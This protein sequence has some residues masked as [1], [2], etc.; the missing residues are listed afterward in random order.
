ML[1]A[2]PGTGKT[3]TVPPAL[4]HEEWLADQRILMVEPRRMAARAAAARMADLA[5]Q[6][7]GKTFGYSVRHDR[8]MSRSTRVETVTEGIF[9]NRIQRDPELSGVGLVILDEFHE[10]SLESDMALAFLLEARDSLREDLRILVMSATIDAPKVA[11]FIAGEGRSA[12]VIEVEAP[13]YPIETIH[14]PPNGH[15]SI[16]DQVASTVTEALAKG[17]GDVLVFLPGRAEIG[18]SHRRLDRLRKSA[19]LVAEIEELHGS[20]PPS[21]QDRILRGDPGGRRRVILA[22]SIAETSVTIPGVRIVVDTGRRRTL[23]TDPRTGLPYLSTTA[24]SMAGAD[25]RR[26]RA[27]RTAPGICYRLWSRADEEHRDDHDEP[28]I[29]SADLSQLTLQAKLWGARDPGEMKWLDPPPLHAVGRAER[30]LRELGALDTRSRVTEHGKS[31]ASYGFHPRLGAIASAAGE[32]HRALA[33]EICAV[34]DVSGP[35]DIELAER[36]RSLRGGSH[37][38]SGGQSREMARSLK[39]WQRA[40]GVNPKQAESGSPAGAVTSETQFNELVGRLASAGFADRIAIRRDGRKD[41]HGKAR[42]VYQ[43]RHGGEVESRSPGSPLARHR[44]I[45][46]LDLDSASGSGRTG[47]LHLG[48]ELSAADA[49]KMTVEHIEEVAQVQLDSDGHLVAERVRKVD[50]MTVDRQPWRNPPSAAVA[51]AVTDE[52]QAR[53]CEWLPR[54]HSADRIRSRLAF[55]IS[56]GFENIPDPSS[57]H[58]QATADHWLLPQLQ[59]MKL[60]NSLNTIDVASA[61][62]AMVDWQTRQLLESEAPTSWV[63]PSGTELE[64]RYGV[65]DGDPGSVMMQARLQLLLGVDVQPTVGSTRTPITVEL[66]SPANR[67]V[68][69]TQDLPGFW[70]GSYCEVRAEMRSRYRKHSWPERP[71]ES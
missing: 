1:V 48:A 28:E 20:V 70:R 45:L 23:R 10:R 38:R 57:E 27:G 3:T 58:L 64:L 35:G 31:I 24:V 32:S 44:W 26:G 67:P 46:A 61:V 19:G 9:T 8:S 33:A 41:K 37:S 21:E 34:L 52:V 42:A 53:G 6:S 49:T 17:S 39:Q 55:L 60:K 18:R 11:E 66:L 30:L 40:V 29:L 15:E 47:R 63:T 22:T 51:R 4:L 16:E 50:A 5:N 54:W 71:W 69:R 59:G 7:V 56:A 2:P 65:V 12:E 43:L 13:L 68:Q 36:V 25:Q 62:W 14:R